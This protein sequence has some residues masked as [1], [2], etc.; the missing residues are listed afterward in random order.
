MKGWSGKMM[1]GKGIFGWIDM[2]LKSNN[3]KIVDV[4]EGIGSYYRR[5]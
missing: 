1:Q 4:A 2:I 3:F 5:I